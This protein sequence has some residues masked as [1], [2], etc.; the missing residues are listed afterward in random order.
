MSRERPILDYRK[1]DGEEVA[2]AE[3]AA[4]S[5]GLWLT[6]C[7]PIG[8]PLWIVSTWFLPSLWNRELAAGLT[9]TSLWVVLTLLGV[10]YGRRVWRVYLPR[11]FWLGF[12]QGVAAIAG[13][14][15][16]CII[17]SVIILAFTGS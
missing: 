10:L 9:S 15:L 13:L 4:R 11:P 5:A 3:Q 2:A 17:A 12:A 6:I 1:P 16:F 8:L 14:L 7:L